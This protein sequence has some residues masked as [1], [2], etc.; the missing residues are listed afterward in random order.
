MKREIPRYKA[1]VV[2]GEG[3]FVENH[4]KK[5][6]ANH[7][8]Q[9]HWHYS[10]DRCRGMTSL[11]AGCSIVLVVKDMASH[12]KHRDP[13]HK[14]AKRSGIRAF[15]IQRKW[16]HAAQV[17]IS[18]GV[19]DSVHPVEET[20]MSGS[21]YQEKM[22]AVREYVQSL[23]G[24]RPSIEE[25]CDA[26]GVSSDFLGLY[27]AVNEGIQLSAVKSGSRTAKKEKKKI[28]NNA[29]IEDARETINILIT[30]NPSYLYMGMG[31]LT[32]DVQGF[33]NFPPPS[34]RQLCDMVREAIQ[35]F[36][37]TVALVQRRGRPTAETEEARKLV[38]EMR[39]NLVMNMLKQS[40][41]NDGT[42]PTV[43]MIQEKGRRVFGGNIPQEMLS[44]LRTSFIEEKGLSNTQPKS[45]PQAEVETE[46]P[47][48]VEVPKMGKAQQKVMAVANLL[49]KQTDTSIAK[50]AGVSKTTVQLVRKQLG[51]E[52][53]ASGVSEPAPRR[54]Y[55]T[56]PPDHQDPSIAAPEPSP[57]APVVEEVD[58]EEVPHDDQYWRRGHWASRG[59]AQP[60]T[61]ESDQAQA[62]GNAI[63]DLI[64][65][66]CKVKFSVESPTSIEGNMEVATGE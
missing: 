17:L 36:K 32:L 4:L 27:R 12:S 22:T 38:N 34:K 5:R 47:Q 42:I 54:S 1:L 26:T 18:A 40:Y 61:Q 3:V 30:E 33:I 15:D 24:R 62:I 20:E 49:G 10:W 28:I 2:G 29:A 7:G 11:P 57:T 63:A 31:A 55:V 45:T 41:K 19:I 50:L 44:T 21:S 16:C 60:K 6:L 25:V 8:I 43:S 13:V 59:T 9:V 35:S 14:L 46:T 23:E 37:E 51:I 48:K 64:R 52:A 56:V 66:G 53:Y 65:A 39:K 58:A